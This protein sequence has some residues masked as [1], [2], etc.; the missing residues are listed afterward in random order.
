MQFTRAELREFLR[1]YKGAVHS[2]HSDGILTVESVEGPVPRAPWALDRIDQMRLPLDGAF[3][4]YNTGTGIN[5]YIVDT[6]WPRLC[7][8]NACHVFGLHGLRGCHPWLPLQLAW[9]A[10][11]WTQL[12]F[13]KK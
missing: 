7:I 3:H 2:V 10:R 9:H 11:A 4:Y 6:V 5:I 12:A 13:M 8:C 1:A